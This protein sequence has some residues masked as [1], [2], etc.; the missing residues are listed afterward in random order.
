MSRA[1]RSARRRRPRGHRRGIT[2]GSEGV[3]DP[4][5][6]ALFEM[7][8]PSIT[9]LASCVPRPSPR[10][11]RYMV[12]DTEQQGLCLWDGHL[13]A[14]TL[15]GANASQ[16]EIISVVPNRHLERQRWPLF[17]GIRG[18]TW[19]LSCGT[20]PEPRLSLEDVGVMELFSADKDRATPFTFYKTFG[21][22]THTFE[23]AAFP[24]LFLSTAPGEEL[25]LAPP[26]GATAF[27]LR[28]M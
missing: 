9:P 18:G 12:R 25:A 2:A 19:A 16:E 10:P 24:G 13:V 28:R 26:P 4:D 14:T 15:Q 7:F 21:G 6:V 8:L 23:A 17:L 1:S 27:Y 3:I 11:F 20:G 5:M 22:S